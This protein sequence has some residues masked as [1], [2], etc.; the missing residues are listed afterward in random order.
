MTVAI[1]S[2]TATAKMTAV[3]FVV[4]NMVADATGI[5]RLGKSKKWIGI[6]TRAELAWMTEAQVRMVYEELID[7][8]EEE[9]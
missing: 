2:S 3:T 6:L 7:L 8:I 5:T 4:W 1:A 9:K